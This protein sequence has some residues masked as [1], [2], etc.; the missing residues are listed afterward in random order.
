MIRNIELFR[1]ELEKINGWW[2]TGKVREA[3]MF[4]FARK[5]L[6]KIKEELSLR[7]ISMLIGPRRVGKSVLLKHAI[8]LLLKTENPRN[9]LFFSADDPSLYAFSNSLIKDI[10]DYWLENIAKEGKKFI[11][12]DEVHLYG[13]WHKWL[14]SYYD[15][16]LDI[17]LVVSGS[18]SLILQK[19]ANKWLR[20]RTSE[21]EIFPL[22]FAEFL[23]LYGAKQETLKFSD[24]EKMDEW[25][26]KENYGKIREPFNEYLLAGGF[27]EWFEIKKAKGADFQIWFEKLLADAPKKAIYEDIANIFGIKNLK[28]LE[29]IMSFIAANQSRLL[30]YETINDIAGLD[31]ATLVN[32]L[33]FLKSSY[34]IMEILKFAG[35]KEQMKAKKKYL[36]IDQGLRNALLKEYNIKEDNAGFIIENV[37]GIKLFSVCRERKANLFYFTNGEVDFVLKDEAA[38][39]VESKYRNQIER[40]EIKNML[41]FL[42]DNKMEY[43]IAVTKEL[44]KTETFGSKKIY[45][46]PAWLFLLL[47][48]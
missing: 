21:I 34:L 13:D 44:F 9:I 40:K 18:S 7:R 8:N 26:I 33:E 4:P 22:D 35:I 48:F 46:I 30:S 45:F 27:P 5:H 12:I 31:R 39:P 20:G 14:K 19:E 37:I 24:I 15:K 38:I 2:I 11:F 29:T 17:K 6:E 47:E 3:E 36:C 42:E 28:V 41:N 23:E 16:Y 25:K 1:N 10:I 43:G 32:Y